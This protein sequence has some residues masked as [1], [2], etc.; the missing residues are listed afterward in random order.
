M[1]VE[2]SNYTTKYTLTRDVLRTDDG[3][4]ADKDYFKGDIIFKYSGC[5]YGCVSDDGMAM[6]EIE[7][8]GPFFQ[9]PRD[10]LMQSPNVQQHP[11][12]KE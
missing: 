9:M 5:T 2:K 4:Y 3:S 10:A 7:G 12:E 8:E 6:C 1:K 11:A